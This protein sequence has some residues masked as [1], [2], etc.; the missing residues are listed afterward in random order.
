M[1]K[2]LCQVLGMDLIPTLKHFIVSRRI[3]CH[4]LQK[5]SVGYLAQL[6]AKLLQSSSTLCD[7]DCS[8]PG[9]SVWDSPGKNTGVGCHFLLQG[10]FQ[11]QGSN[12]DLLRLSCIGRWVL[13]HQLHLGSLSVILPTSNSFSS[14]LSPYT[15]TH[16]HTHTP[17]HSLSPQSVKRADVTT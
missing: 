4:M 8:P 11:T 9:S 6:H 15:H 3:L 10:I 13:Y 2:A 16:T 7:L 14:L 17:T 12:P 5:G 1:C